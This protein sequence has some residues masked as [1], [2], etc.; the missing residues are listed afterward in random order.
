MSLQAD[1]NGLYHHWRHAWRGAGA[2]ADGDD[3]LQGL[4]IRYAEP[5][6]A[7]HN[8]D[9]VADCLHHADAARHLATRPHEVA[10]AAWFHDAV[11]DPRR[12]D[13]EAR[14]AQLAET[15][16]TAAGVAGDATRRIGALIRATTHEREEVGGDT[17]VLCDADLAILGAEPERFAWYEAA[18]RREYEWVD[19]AVYRAGR[20]RVLRR[21]LSRRVIYHTAFFAARLE[22]SARVNLNRALE[23][24][25]S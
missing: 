16:L 22:R 18:I 9:H 14:S 4:M 5:H 23:D 13:N 2:A 19:E 11:Y 12:S 15:A 10:L 8:L 7:Y 3:V 21:F 20:G 24:Y 17:A 1:R 25:L 6:R